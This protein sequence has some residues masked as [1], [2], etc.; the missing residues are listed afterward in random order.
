MLK[1]FRNFKIDE[2]KKYFMGSSEEA[3]E[4]N[5]KYKNFVERV[6]EE[7]N[8]S[9]KQAGRFFTGTLD[10]LIKRKLNLTEYQ[11]HPSVMQEI[12]KMGEDEALAKV[13]EG[14][15]F[16]NTITV[17]GK[18]YDYVSRPSI[19]HTSPSDS[20]GENMILIRNS[21]V[22]ILTPRN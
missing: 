20:Q 7:L 13:V 21:E 8:I 17:D 18:S 3:S 10:R 4:L 19:N 14:E 6:K 9:D 2:A 5:T 11:D 16:D 22:L 15:D 1:K 12:L